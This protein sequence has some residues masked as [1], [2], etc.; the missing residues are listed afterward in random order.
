M[1]IAIAVNCLLIEPIRNIVCGV[2]ETCFSLSAW[3]YPLLNTIPLW[4]TRTEPLKFAS[5]LRYVSRRAV[6]ALGKG[7]TAPDVVMGVGKMWAADVTDVPGE[8]P[9]TLTKLSKRKSSPRR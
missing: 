9:P 7:G 8:L 3:P 1:R 5:S 2:L 6:V 4:A